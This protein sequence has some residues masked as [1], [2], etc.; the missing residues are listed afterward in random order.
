MISNIEKELTLSWQ[1]AYLIVLYLSAAI[2]LGIAVYAWLQR[3]RPGLLLF[4]FMMLTVACYT[5]TAG[6]MS[7]AATPEGANRWVH[8]HYISLTSMVA[9]YFS[10]IL[11]F[12]GHEKWLNKFTMAIFFSVP[13]IT[14]IIIETNPIHHWFIQEIQF[15]QDGILQGLATIRYGGFFW[16]HTLYSYALVLGGI[17][18]M[19]R[20]SV[21]TFKLYRV[22]SLTLFVAVLAPLLGSINDSKVFIAGFPYPIVPICFTFMGI[23]IAWNMFRNQMLSIIPVARDTLIESMQDSMIVLDAA[24]QIIDINPAA[25][26]LFGFSAEQVIGRP[27]DEV[28][29]PWKESLFHLRGKMEAEGE[30]SFT[31]D[32]NEKYLDIQISPLKKIR[33]KSSGQ[34]LILR[35]VTK[36]VLMEQKNQ[37][38]LQDIQNLQQ[39]LY[40]SSI[41]DDLTGLYNRRYLDEVLPREI[42]N[43]ARSNQPISFVMMDIDHFKLINDTYGHII[44]DQVL[45]N[46]SHCLKEQTR[47]GDMVFRFGGEEFLAILVNSPSD[48]AVHYAE[49][50]LQSL[51]EHNISHQG[52]EI[53]ITMS[54][55]VAEF[56]RD[57]DT[58]M[59]VLQAADKAMYQAKADGRNSVSMFQA[60][61]GKKE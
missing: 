28:M 53:R 48:A 10:F 11:Q 37:Q 15:K 7:S 27:I 47:A 40:E 2:S 12:T 56:N 6:L 45:Q 3:S 32:G 21:R 36:R 19:I 5:L 26:K 60:G 52:K 59:E 33:G 35:D 13:V 17:V 44:G 61:L 54:M 1:P 24:R 8:L 9:F 25:L 34:I 50:W 42:A 49:R 23:L 55:G 4:A 51:Q 38:A 29:S 20:M 57:G 31:Q 22:Q 43:A 14:Q 16:F 41:H 18:L 39:Q 58:F 46:V 30:I